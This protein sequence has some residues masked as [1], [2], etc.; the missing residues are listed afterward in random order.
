MVKE[1]AG[2]HKGRI[3]ITS[4]YGKGTMAGLWIPLAK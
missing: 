3:E 1:V 4:E 2:L